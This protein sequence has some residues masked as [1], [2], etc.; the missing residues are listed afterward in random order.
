MNTIGFKRFALSI[1]LITV[2]GATL[3]ANQP[4]PQ[5]QSTPAAWTSF[6]IRNNFLVP[7]MAVTD[8]PLTTRIEEYPADTLFS[9]NANHLEILGTGRVQITVNAHMGWHIINTTAFTYLTACMYKADGSS[10]GAGQLCTDLDWRPY[11][12]GSAGSFY[13]SGVINMRHVLVPDDFL[14]GSPY[15]IF[16]V[17]SGADRTEP[18]DLDFTVTLLQ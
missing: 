7:R 6:S 15:L 18:W 17:Y 5:R 8:V 1:L 11:N 3:A 12:I 2:I 14:G 13:E 9:Y 4:A 16:R 10:I